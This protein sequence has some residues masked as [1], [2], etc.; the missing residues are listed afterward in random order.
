MNPVSQMATNDLESE[1]LFLKVMDFYKIK[2]DIDFINLL[3]RRRIT[4]RDFEKCDVSVSNLNTT[5]YAIY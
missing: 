1:E 4:R 5:E 2:P 3:I